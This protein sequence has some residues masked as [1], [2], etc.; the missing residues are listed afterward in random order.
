MSSRPKRFT[1]A[2][3][4]SCAVS[5][6]ERLQATA[7]QLSCPS[8]LTSCSDGAFGLLVIEQHPRSRGDKHADRGRADT[9]RTAGDEGNLAR[10]RKEGG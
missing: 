3:T 4:N 9:A 2:A 1:A 7:A 6:P 8:S 10:E 5:V